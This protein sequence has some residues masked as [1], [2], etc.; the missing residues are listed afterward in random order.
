MLMVA[1]SGA[2]NGDTGGP[3]PHRIFRNFRS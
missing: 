1:Y 2:A 3:G